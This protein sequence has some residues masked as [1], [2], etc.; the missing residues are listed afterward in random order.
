MKIGCSTW[1]FHDAFATRTLDQI[2]FA[3]LAAEL[4]LD[5]IELLTGTFPSVTSGTRPGKG[6]PCTSGFSL[7]HSVQLTS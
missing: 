7:Q 3:E 5:G 4:G 2:G 1:S 6:I